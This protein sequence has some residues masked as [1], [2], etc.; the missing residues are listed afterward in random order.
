MAVNI[1]NERNTAMNVIDCKVVDVFKEHVAGHGVSKEAYTLAVNS[2]DNYGTMNYDVPVE[3]KEQ[4]ERRKK[5]IEREKLAQKKA[6]KA[7]EAEKWALKMI[8]EHDK[9]QKEKQELRRQQK[10]LERE[11]K[12]KEEIERNKKREETNKQE[13]RPSLKDAKIAPEKKVEQS[14]TPE[15]PKKKRLEPPLGYDDKNYEY[16]EH[17][18]CWVPASGQNM[19][20]VEWE[21]K[22]QEEKA[23]AE[24]EGAKKEEKPREKPPW[25]YDGTNYE[26]NEVLRRWLRKSGRHNWYKGGNNQ[27]KS[28]PDT[29]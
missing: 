23:R 19:Y 5:L 1:L 7:E 29:S 25:N 20:Y 2:K 3:Y 15:P 4:I 11:N 9:E 28:P 27:N 26:Y 22:K 21:K 10:E 14:S 12:E 17:I 6:I 18:N 24:R 13:Q 8:E 16:N